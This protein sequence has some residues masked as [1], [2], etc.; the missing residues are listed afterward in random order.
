[1]REKNFGR[2]EEREEWKNRFFKFL[3]RTATYKYYLIIAAD[4][5]TPSSPGRLPLLTYLLTDAYHEKTSSHGRRPAK[6]IFSRTHTAKTYVLM[7][8]VEVEVEVVEMEAV[9]MEAVEEEEV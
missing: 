8:A 7:D 1:M 9:Q 6:L 3:S 2:T 4:R 5:Q